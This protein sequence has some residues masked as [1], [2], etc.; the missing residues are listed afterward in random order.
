LVRAT[1]PLRY[2]GPFQP[3]PT[4]AKTINL[5]NFAY[6]KYFLKLDDFSNKGLRQLL[7]NFDLNYFGG[8]PLP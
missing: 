4:N 6:G 7:V 5:L 2:G 3:P 8:I 1:N